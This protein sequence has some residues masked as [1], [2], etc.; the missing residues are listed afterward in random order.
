MTGTK[1]IIKDHLW[2]LCVGGPK[3]GHWMC[4]D[5]RRTEAGEIVPAAWSF[6]V[7]TLGVAGTHYTAMRYCIYA[8]RRGDDVTGY[9]A[10]PFDYLF[11]FYS[12]NAI[13][14]ANHGN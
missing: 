12:T 11:S 3:D 5:A 14:A 13:I 4:M 10:T 7:S 9:I 6:D 8:L 1:N 2:V